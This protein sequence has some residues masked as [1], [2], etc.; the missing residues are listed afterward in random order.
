MK[1]QYSF[2]ITL[3]QIR[4]LMPLAVMCSVDVTSMALKLTDSVLS[5]DLFPDSYHGSLVEGKMKLPVRWMAIEQLEA[6]SD[7]RN[8]VY[9]PATDVVSLRYQ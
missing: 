9:E 2:L 7:H 5:S 4:C 3:H 6:V 8:I 1:E